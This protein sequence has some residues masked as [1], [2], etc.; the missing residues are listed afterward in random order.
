MVGLRPACLN[1]P[2]VSWPGVIVA[3]VR[4][5]LAR[6]VKGEGHDKYRLTS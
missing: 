1:D 4:F 3:P 5:N 2:E 6:L